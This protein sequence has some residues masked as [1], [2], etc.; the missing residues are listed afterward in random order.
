MTAVGGHDLHGVP[1]VDAVELMHGAPGTPVRLRIVR[2]G[3]DRPLLLTLV[4]QPVTVSAVSS[5]MLKVHG[6]RVLLVRIPTFIDHTA[7]QVRQIVARAAAG[8]PLDGVIV[9]L[10]GDTGGVLTEGVGVARVLIDHGVIVATDGQREPREVFSG[11]GTAL[12]VGKVAVMIDFATASAAEIVAGALKAH[13]AIV[14]GS[15]SYGK[16][17]VQAVRAAARR[18][19]TEADRR[20]VH[21]GRRPD[22]QRPRGDADRRRAGSVLDSQGRDA[23]RC[24]DGAA[25][26]TH[27]EEPPRAA[28]VVCEVGRRGRL[29]VAE[30][31]FEF[32]VPLTLGRR[33][34]GDVAEGDLVVVEPDGG[35]RGRVVDRLGR[36]DDVRAVLR[37]VAIEQGVAA[38]WPEAVEHEVAELGADPAEGVRVDLRDRVCFTVDPPDARDFD[39][40]IGVEREDGGFRLFVH[41]A[42]V[43]ARVPA[44]SAL[45]AEAALRGCSVYLPGMV[46]PMLPER[47][48]ADL[49]SLRPDVDRGAVTVEIAPDG[50]MTAYRSLI[51]SRARLGY[52]QAERILAGDEHVAEDV[53]RALH[54]AAA[55]AE[56]LRAERFAH[57][58]A[59]I[60]SR[61]VEFELRDGR[62][63]AAHEAE[64]SVAH[65]L[66]EE[67]M[68]LA[69]RRVAE[70]LSGVRAPAIYR[71]HPSPDPVAVE[72]LVERLAAL[73]VPTPPQPEL[74]TPAQAGAYA[75]AVARVGGAVRRL[76]GAGQGGVPAAR[77]AVAGARPLRHAEPRTLR[78]GVPRV[79]PLHEPDPP[80]P[81]PGLP[82]GA[83]RP[84]GPGAARTG[85]RGRARATAPRRA[86]TASGRRRWSSAAATTSAWRSCWRTCCSIAAGTSRSPARWS[87]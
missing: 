63:A 87:G 66:V 17:T 72:S 75:A 62:V 68:L 1:Y 77:P 27:A 25:R 67:L 40:A 61:E 20:L 34:A 24:A 6:R 12:K 53:E 49:C 30:P 85:R 70:L 74:H 26:V 52:P 41:I 23:G 18:R 76:V 84:P 80:L 47:L 56:R 21:A 45:D 81:R 65:Q 78:A 38:P 5:R 59:H 42:D 37:G 79:L 46:E 10:R 73:E 15:P 54:D 57:G 83:G 48:S 31:F 60:E 33:G 64:E 4:R 35:G 28:P 22:R 19:C 55:V 36:P 58:A 51:R 82:P 9:D 8:K 43:S 14:A 86:R 69:N 3:R 32:G 11:N 50:A 7:S 2:P 71:V 13:G 39:D 29:L 44:G 16:G